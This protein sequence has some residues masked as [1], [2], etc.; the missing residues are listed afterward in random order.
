[1]NIHL[2]TLMFKSYCC[3]LFII[4][5]YRLHFSEQ[6]YQ[7]KTEALYRGVAFLQPLL[8]G[9]GLFCLPIFTGN[10]CH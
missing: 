3:D 5:G 8:Q 6:T 7:V 9:I 10:V 2:M 1:M 4:Y